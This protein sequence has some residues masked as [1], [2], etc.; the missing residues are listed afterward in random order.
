MDMLTK[1]ERLIIIHRRSLGPLHMS[2]VDRAGQVSEISLYLW[3]LCKIFDVFTW[4]GGL[5][6]FLRNSGFPT[7]ISGKGLDILPYE[8]MNKAGWILAAQIASS[9]IA[10]CILRI[11]SIPFNCSDTALRV[12]RSYDRFESYSFCVSPRLLCFLNFAPELAPGSLAFSHLGDRAKISHM[13][14]K[15]NWSR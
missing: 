1:S 4:E 3:I 8:H 10:C 6:R 15:L 2:L 13:K 12:C 7:G 5:A 9:R 14:P 11:I